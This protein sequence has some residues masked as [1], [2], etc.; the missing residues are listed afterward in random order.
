MS[1][2]SFDISS[3]TEYILPTKFQVQHSSNRSG[4]LFNGTQILA[5]NTRIRLA[6]SFPGKEKQR[7]GERQSVLTG[8]TP[9]HYG[10]ALDVPH[11]ME[12]SISQGHATESMETFFNLLQ[13]AFLFCTGFAIARVTTLSSKLS[14]DGIKH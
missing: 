6:R 13:I 7:F 5:N 2:C 12:H 1:R 4:K 11:L 14:P 10:I 3:I 8:V 9:T